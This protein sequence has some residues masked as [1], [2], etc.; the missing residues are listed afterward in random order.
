MAA[1]PSRQPPQ[2]GTASAN[3]RV[4]ETANSAG[5][6]AKCTKENAGS[7]PNHAKATKTIAMPAMLMPQRGTATIAIF[8]SSR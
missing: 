8:S 4:N 2:V 3:V 7:A 6:F 5:A 1:S